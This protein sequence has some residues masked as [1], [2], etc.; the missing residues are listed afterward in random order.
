M[1]S[2]ICQPMSLIAILNLECGGTWHDDVGCSHAKKLLKLY[3]PCQ[4]VAN[5]LITA[6]CQLCWDFPEVERMMQQSRD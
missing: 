1:L 2:M 4:T 3:G 5:E 6:T